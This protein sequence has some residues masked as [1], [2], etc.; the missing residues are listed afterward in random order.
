MSASVCCHQT[1]CYMMN[2]KKL[3]VL[4]HSAHEFLLNVFKA[5]LS[6]LHR[7]RIYP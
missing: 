5:Q 1:V 6:E 3:Q 7:S 4:V 2:V